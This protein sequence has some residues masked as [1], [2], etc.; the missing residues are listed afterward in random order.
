MKIGNDAGV[1]ATVRLN[2]LAAVPGGLVAIPP[3]L[4]TFLRARLDPEE[5]VVNR[6][7]AADVLSRA[8]LSSEQLVGLAESVKVVGPMELDRLLEAFAQSSDERVGL[9]LVSA[10]R[11][12]PARSAPAR[13]RSSGAWQSSERLSRA[14]PTICIPA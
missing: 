1:P 5:P 13:T 10:L 14:R 3:S 7:L 4:F 9:L 8:K 6:G 12:S 11:A 2:A